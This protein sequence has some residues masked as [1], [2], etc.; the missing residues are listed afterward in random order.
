MIK[1][2]CDECGKEFNLGADKIQIQTRDMHINKNLQ[3]DVVYYKCPFCGVPFIIQICDK[4]AYELQVELKKQ[5][6]RWQRII[7]GNDP[8]EVDRN[9]DVYVSLLAKQ[10]RLKDHLTMTKH[11]YEEIVKA[12]LMPN[13]QD[14]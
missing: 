9:R 13:N 4:R 12:N 8:D 3:L 14:V 11:W 2:V 7:G 5:K 10:K 6:A 1:I